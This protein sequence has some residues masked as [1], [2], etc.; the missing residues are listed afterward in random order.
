M[1]K[2]DDKTE[3]TKLTTDDLLLR[4]FS[5]RLP[6]DMRPSPAEEAELERLVKA[7]ED[8]SPRRRG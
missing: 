3:P 1:T 7:S 8:L 4:L 2:P 5:M 6:V